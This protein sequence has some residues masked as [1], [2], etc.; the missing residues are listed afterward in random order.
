MSLVTPAL[1]AVQ[2]FETREARR[3]A[4]FHAPEEVLERQIQALEGDLFGL[5]VDTAQQFR[6]GAPLGQP[7]ALGREAQ[8]LLP[9]APGPASLSQGLVPQQAV[10]PALML[11]GGSLG[12]RG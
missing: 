7:L 8:R 6:L 9:F 10:D 2:R 4:L 1:E 5:G 3:L 11:Q 12:R